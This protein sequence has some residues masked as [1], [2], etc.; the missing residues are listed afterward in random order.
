ML[1][2]RAE[3]NRK[4]VGSGFRWTQTSPGSL[5]SSRSSHVDAVGNIS[6]SNPNSMSPFMREPSILSLCPSLVSQWT[7]TWSSYLPCLLVTALLQVADYYTTS[8]ATQRVD[9]HRLASVASLASFLSASI[10]AWLIWWLFPPVDHTLSAGVVIAIVLFVL[11]TPSLTRPLSRS[12]GSLV[13]YSTSGLPLYQSLQKT[14]PSLLEAI[15]P[16]LVKIM[17][18]TDS[19]RIFY[20]LIL[21]LVRA[22]WRMPHFWLLF[23]LSMHYVFRLSRLLSC[24]MECGQTVLA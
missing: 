6:T 20:F 5:Y 4:K 17:E 19:R 18:N 11:V 22:T 12:Q 3:E 2:D 15:R 14:P 7:V 9:H 13:G 10:W 1:D 23:V 24:C 8:I 16:A 21:N